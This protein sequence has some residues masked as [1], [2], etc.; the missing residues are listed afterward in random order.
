ML[1]AAVS[2]PASRGTQAQ[3]SEQGGYISQDNV[4]WNKEH[5]QRAGPR[6]RITGG[7]IARIIGQVGLVEKTGHLKGTG[8]IVYLIQLEDKIDGKAV[9]IITLQKFTSE[10]DG[11]Q[12][13]L[14]SP[15]AG[16]RCG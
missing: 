3:A 1:P 10:L 12:A 8:A 6:V 14:A 13:S 4:T 9:H 5:P 16:A 11:T 7:S 2:Q 15:A